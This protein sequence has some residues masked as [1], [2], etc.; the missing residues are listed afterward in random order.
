MG[1]YLV[2]KNVFFVFGNLLLRHLPKRKGNHISIAEKKK[3]GKN[4]VGSKE[5]GR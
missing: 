4:R 3:P 2:Q 5:K 1:T